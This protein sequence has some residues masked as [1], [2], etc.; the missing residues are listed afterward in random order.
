MPVLNK[1]PPESEEEERAIRRGEKVRK[2]EGEKARFGR[3][4][5]LF[6]FNFEEKNALSDLCRSR[7]F[8][9]F[10]RFLRLV[11]VSPAPLLSSRRAPS[12]L[13]VLHRFFGKN[14]TARTAWRV[15]PARSN[16]QPKILCKK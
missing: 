3:K 13:G 5:Q 9:T 4:F 7:S 1:K 16:Q 14:A 6:V 8:F 12:A 11:C 10:A 15:L 2:R